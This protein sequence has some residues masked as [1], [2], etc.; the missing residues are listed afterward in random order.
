MIKF[1]R[2]SKKLG[3]VQ[4]LDHLD[5]EIP[6]GQLLAIVGLSGSGKSTAVNVMAGL[7]PIDSGRYL[8]DGEDV[9]KA[10]KNNA[11][12][13]GLRRRTGYISQASD[14]MANFSAS[15]NIK[16]AGWCRGITVDDD[17]VRDVLEAV[18]LDG[19]E[20]RAPQSISGGQRQRVNIA[21]GLACKP[22]AIFA[23]EP[24]GALDI[25]TGQIVIDNLID[26][27]KSRGITLILVTHSPEYAAL[28]ERQIVLHHGR[29]AY[30]E[31]T[32]DFKDIK[33]RIDDCAKD[34][35]R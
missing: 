27:S 18:E 31:S 20:D 12:A 4:A 21:R 1:E 25:H 30:D 13:I 3:D 6:R 5:L 15:E 14:M 17:T 22:Q 34:V 23:D 28:C 24:T 16:I 32:S 29:I 8:F 33:R 9:S 35:P 10:R 26:V 11:T 7:L 2:V 19:F